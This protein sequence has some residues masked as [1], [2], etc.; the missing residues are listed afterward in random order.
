MGRWVGDKQRPRNIQE[1]VGL[2]CLT[3]SGGGVVR[4]EDTVF[5]RLSSSVL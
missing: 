4:E 3:E 1:T 5:I 2:W